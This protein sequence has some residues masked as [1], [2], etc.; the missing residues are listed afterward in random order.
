MIWFAD[1][2]ADCRS[3]LWLVSAAECYKVANASVP[4][5][6]AKMLRAITKTARGS[7]LLAD[8]GLTQSS[9]REPTAASF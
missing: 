1:G 5:P 3:E 6:A 8:T 2:G 7:G 4:L 9:T